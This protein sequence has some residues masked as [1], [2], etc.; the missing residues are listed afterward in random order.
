M[1]VSTP[2]IE[3]KLLPKFLWLL[4]IAMRSSRLPSMALEVACWLAEYADENG[5]AW[6]ARSTLAKLL[7]C[8]ER[9]IG[10]ALAGL[11]KDGWIIPLVEHVGPGIKQQWQ[12]NWDHRQEFSCVGFNDDTRRRVSKVMGKHWKEPASSAARTSGDRWKERAAIIG[13]NLHTIPLTH[14]TQESL[15]KS[16]PSALELKRDASA[17]LNRAIKARGG[18]LE[19]L[20]DDQNGAAIQEE[21]IDAEARSPGSGISLVVDRLDWSQKKARQER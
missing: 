2:R 3:S 11:R 7:G 13:K 17:R 1:K 12:I 15:R 8:S 21:A 10:S 5:R 16:L 20:L 14:P 19:Y 9:T 18:L 4:A 6:P